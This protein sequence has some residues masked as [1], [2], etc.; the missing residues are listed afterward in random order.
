MERQTDRTKLIFSFC[1]FA[2][3]PKSYTHKQEQNITFMDREKKYFLHSCIRKSK[4]AI[5]SLHSYFQD[6]AYR[7]H[8]W[9]SAHMTFT[10]LLLSRSKLW[11]LWIPSSN[12][13]FTHNIRFWWRFWRLLTA[14]TLKPVLLCNINFM[15]A[16]TN[17]Y[18][19][20]WMF[21]TCNT[22]INGPLI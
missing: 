16:N 22:Q 1:N 2:Y 15:T 8:E 14:L 4:R 18:N 13:T 6:N 11:S 17:K 3:V 20:S 7:C 10:T 21:I 5:H 19:F 9:G 12:C